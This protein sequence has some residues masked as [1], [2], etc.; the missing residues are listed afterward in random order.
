[1]LGACVDEQE[2]CLHLPFGQALHPLI[3][4]MPL[5]NGYARSA[6]AASRSGR[7]F[8]RWGERL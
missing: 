3:W 6:V 8:S 5:D 2:Q 4:A 7:A 1:M